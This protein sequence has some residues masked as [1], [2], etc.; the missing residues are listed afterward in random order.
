M[1]LRYFRDEL[2]CRVATIH[3]STSA[4]NPV[5]QNLYLKAGYEK[6]GEIVGMVGKGNVEIQMVKDVDDVGY[7][8]GLWVKL[9]RD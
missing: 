4:D 9:K 7:R 2:K 1:V 5:A 3:L 6:R 8:E